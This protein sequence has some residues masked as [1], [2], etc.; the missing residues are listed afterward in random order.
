[1]QKGTMDQSYRQLIVS[2]PF[3]IWTEKPV[4]RSAEIEPAVLPSEFVMI[5][6]ITST[7]LQ[8]VFPGRTKELSTNPN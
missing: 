4:I 6:A 1:M 8:A 2:K 5:T 3:G 7:A